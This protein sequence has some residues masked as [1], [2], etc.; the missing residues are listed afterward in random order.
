MSRFRFT[1]MVLVLVA[2]A[3]GGGDEE[4]LAEQ[5]AWCLDNFDIVEDAADDLGLLDFVDTWYDTEGDG[6]G[7]DGEPVPT[8]KNFDVSNDLSARNAED[9]DGLFDDLV[10]RYFNHTDGQAAC[11][12]AYTEEA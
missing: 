3:C 8:D 9:P 7:A 2:A 12:A 1:V 11:S 5:R 10:E 4:L 6:V